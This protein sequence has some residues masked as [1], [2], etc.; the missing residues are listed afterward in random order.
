GVWGRWRVRWSREPAPARQERAGLAAW[1]APAPL[2]IRTWSAGERIR[3]LGGT[4]HRLLVRCF[5]DARVPRSRR[6]G[7]PVLAGPG[8]VVWIP[9]VSRSDALLPEAGTEA[10][11]VDAEHT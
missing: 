4:G 11:R 9:G 6:A 7:W 2:V 10:V 5:Q 3:P 8:G 1:F